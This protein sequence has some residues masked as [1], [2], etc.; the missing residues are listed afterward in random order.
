MLYDLLLPDGH[1]GRGVVLTLG[2]RE[3][4]G[5]RWLLVAAERESLDALEAQMHLILVLGTT[6]GLLLAIAASW[7]VIRGGL[8]P[9]D[10][11]GASAGKGE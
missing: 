3:D 11:L 5:A 9:V 8:R 1:R 7:L 10:A 2:Q 6:V 4:I